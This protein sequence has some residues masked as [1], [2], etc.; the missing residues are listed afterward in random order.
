MTIMESDMT[1]EQ[2][3]LAAIAARPWGPFT[4]AEEDH[5]NSR[6]RS[7]KKQPQPCDMSDRFRFL[8]KGE[9][10]ANIRTTQLPGDSV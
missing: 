7:T 2:R 8:Q 3:R 9:D 1:F 6:L 5:L 10:L 4:Q